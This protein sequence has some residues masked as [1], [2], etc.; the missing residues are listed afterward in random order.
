MRKPRSRHLGWPLLWATLAGL[1]AC[2]GFSPQQLDTRPTY[3]FTARAPVSAAG[4]GLYAEVC[5]GPQQ[6]GGTGPAAAACP[7]F[8]GLLPAAV[9][10]ADALRLQYLNAYMNDSG[11]PR[12]L[13]L[14][15]VPLSA[16]ALYRGL[17]ST[18]DAGNRDVA[19]AALLGGTAYSVTRYNESP[20]R[21]QIRLAAADSLNCAIQG[22]VTRYLYEDT[23]VLGTGTTPGLVE[24]MRRVRDTVK[25]LTKEVDRLGRTQRDTPAQLSRPGR[26]GVPCDIERGRSY[27]RRKGEAGTPPAVTQANPALQVYQDAQQR[28]SDALTEASKALAGGADLK[29][30]I[31]GAAWAL[32]ATVRQIEVS[33]ARAVQ[34]TEA[35]VES[36]RRSVTGLRL[37]AQDVGL[38][39]AKGALAGAGSDV[40][41]PLNGPVTAHGAL[42]DKGVTAQAPAVTVAE[43][44]VAYAGV[45][46]AELAQRVAGIEAALQVDRQRA[47]RLRGQPDCRFTAPG[48]R[49]LVDPAGT[50]TMA[51]GE[52]RQFTA[53]G[54]TE[55]PSV[56]LLSTTGLSAADLL[57]AER[58]TSA[59]RQVLTVA[60]TIKAGTAN[61]DLT[62]VF[63]NADLI[64]TRLVQV[65]GVTG[66]GK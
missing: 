61:Q 28:N 3:G 62:L 15:L 54:G 1:A 59:G 19:R 24:S 9:D 57:R 7:V 29:D 48:L 22:S 13:E 16:Y 23:A 25:L 44:D 2:A 65:R 35:D 39:A 42:N 4:R 5:A 63:R 8:Y 32:K 58:D 53:Q 43:A 27:C 56:A 41:G 30:R 17:F 40:P 20:P 31:D 33:V 52:V 49:L 47:E 6:A 38:P 26:Y 36:V 64:E 45:L 46:R 51:P 10:D 11:A 18:S 21:Q 12:A 50:V 37:V 60:L 34:A 66:A 55:L 14:A